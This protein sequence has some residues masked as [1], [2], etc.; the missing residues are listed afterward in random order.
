MSITIILTAM[1]QLLFYYL[2]YNIYD[3]AW[4]IIDSRDTNYTTIMSITIILTAFT[5]LPFHYAIS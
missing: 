3:K 5:Q 4:Y 2:F 1:T